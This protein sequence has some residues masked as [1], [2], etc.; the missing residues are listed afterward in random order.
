[1][2]GPNKHVAAGDRVTTEIPSEAATALDN[3]KNKT[4]TKASTAVDDIKNETQ[5]EAVTVRNDA[6]S[7]SQDNDDLFGVYEDSDGEDVG[8][9]PQ[10]TTKEQIQIGRM[11]RKKRELTDLYK[12]KF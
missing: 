6:T 2:L 12:G 11:G 4:Q 5:N 8:S 9:S 10:K 1:M 7:K 3:L